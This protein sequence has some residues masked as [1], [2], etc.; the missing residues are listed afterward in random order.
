VGTVGPVG[1][2]NAVR[3]VPNNGGILASAVDPKI[4][5]PDIWLY[6]TKRET[7]ARLTYLPGYEESPVLTSDG[8]R[9]VYSSDADGVPD[10]FIKEV[11]AMTEDRL[12]VAEPGLQNP[13]DISPDGKHVVY[14]TFA[15]GQPDLFVTPLDGSAKPGAFV[16]TP[17]VE[18][19]ARFSPDGRTIAYAS[20]E[21]G[22]Y[23]I[24]VKPFPGPG[25][26]RAVSTKGGEQPRWSRD[27]RQLY[28]SNTRRIYV[29]D[30]SAPDGEPR[31]L[32]EADRTFSDF[33]VAPDGQRFLMVMT[34]D[35]AQQTP[36]RVIVNW[37]E[38]L[39][40]PA[41]R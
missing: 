3:V 30:M 21:T 32:F 39:T 5:T 14:V 12:L 35:L 24:Y 20:N 15:E 38:L 7:A 1:A 31:V 11:G 28:F 17:F 25:L 10:I 18:R 36:T 34:D 41:A 6:G 29:A 27:G 2:F 26:A 19:D 4:G 13:E 8:R 40:R 16:R 37:P 23:E 22:R 33:D 9:L